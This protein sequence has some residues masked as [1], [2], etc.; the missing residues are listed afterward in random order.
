VL[1]GTTVEPKSKSAG[2]VKAEKLT[3]AL[4][5]CRAKPNVKR[6]GCEAV[7]RKRYGSKKA[8]AKSSGRVK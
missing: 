8:K 6:R 2:Q 4:K 5:A 7:A 1:P 3:K